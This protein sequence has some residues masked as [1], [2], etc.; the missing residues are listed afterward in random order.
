[1]QKYLKLFSI[2]LI[3]SVFAGCTKTHRIQESVK[4]IPEQLSSHAVFSGNCDK[5]FYSS[6]KENLYKVYQLDLSKDSITESKIDIPIAQDVFV[7]S[8]SADCRYLSFV[9][10]DNGNQKYDV[11]LYDLVTKQVQNL[12]S[13]K[14]S[15][16]GNPQFSPSE[17]KLAWVA[18]GL[19][20]I[21]SV[22]RKEIIYNSSVRVKSFLWSSDS[23]IFYEDANSNIR[24]LNT[25]NYKDSI[26]WLS[27]S[28]SHVP[29]MFHYSDNTLRFISD[30][31]GFS[32]IYCLNLLSKKVTVPI[33]TNH[34]IYSPQVDSI[35]N[36]YFRMNIHGEILNYY[37][38][39][40]GNITKTDNSASGISYQY[41][42]HADKRINLF[43]D[44]NHPKSIQIVRKG[45]TESIIPK[46]DA[47][48][49]FSKVEKVKTSDNMSHYVFTPIN[50]EAKGWLIWLHGGPQEQI[51]PRFNVFFNFLNKEG[52]GIICIN[53]IGSTGLGNNFELRNSNLS[54]NI[55]IQS[56]YIKEALDTI[57]EKNKINS[58][59]TAVVGVS[60]GAVIAHRFVRD[61]P[62]RVNKIIDLSGLSN[63]YPAPRLSDF[64][65]DLSYLFIVGENDFALNKTKQK[66]ITYCKI[67]AN[68]EMLKIE[69]EG[70]YIRRRK[71]LQKSL[72]KMI[73]FLE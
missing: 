25:I 30:H 32:K 66:Y 59:K 10:D 12:T 68:A 11:F 44:M 43:S 72:N 55:K 36:L 9:A 29:K 21:Y 3:F 45:F 53:Y 37:R 15:D 49:I 7:R 6:N 60:Y 47:L 51:S 14:N 50:N 19:L 56:V 22:I 39:S 35:G 41:F 46:N 4:S 1:M 31:D 63:R 52:W 64:N 48:R 58:K 57:F 40:D 2:L 20:Q 18:S 67:I 5:L 8:V 33:N 24:T 38:D 62:G 65:S 26:L 27:P 42:L 34:D 23:L 70:H 28:K 71:S 54:E 73:T 16:E 61:Y 13:S 17:N 69:N